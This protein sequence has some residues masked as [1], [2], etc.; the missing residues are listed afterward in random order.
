MA[1]CAMS[2]EKVNVTEDN[3]AILGNYGEYFFKN[4]DRLNLVAAEPQI[5]VNTNVIKFQFGQRVEGE[6]PTYSTNSA[7][8]NS[9][10]TNH[11]QET[12]TFNGSKQLK[13]IRNQRFHLRL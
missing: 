11:F 4:Q 9:F 10:E 1:V 7:T 5:D 6:K 3:V 8:V 2:V 12:I 13:L